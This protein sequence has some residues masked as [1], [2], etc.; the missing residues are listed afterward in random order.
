MSCGGRGI[1]SDGAA[2]VERAAEGAKIRAEAATGR[3]R[4]EWEEDRSA[5]GAETSSGIPCRAN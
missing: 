2:P 1:K 4:R 5:G 3:K